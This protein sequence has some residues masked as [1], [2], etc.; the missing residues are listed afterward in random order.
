MNVAEME[1]VSQLPFKLPRMATKIEGHIGHLMLAAER[2]AGHVARMPKDMKANFGAAVVD[3]T[4]WRLK[5]LE[6]VEYLEGKAPQSSKK[7]A[8]ALGCTRETAVK[9]AN[10][11]I[12]QG[13]VIRTPGVGHSDKNPIFVYAIGKGGNT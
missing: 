11:A 8:A 1:V 6:V 7:M 2:K 5:V 9:R 13:M 12:K 10:E 4:K 3:P